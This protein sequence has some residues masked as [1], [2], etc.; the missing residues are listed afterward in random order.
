MLAR[1]CLLSPTHI[2]SPFSS[3]DGALGESTV[4]NQLSEVAAAEVFK[5]QRPAKFEF[6]S[7]NISNQSPC[8]VSIVSSPEYQFFQ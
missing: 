4:K 5:L 6:S 7:S 8:P 3:G 1:S 2:T